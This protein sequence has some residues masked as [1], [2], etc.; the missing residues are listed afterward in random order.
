MSGPTTDEIAKTLSDA[1]WSMRKE[2][3]TGGTPVDEALIRAR[4]ANVNPVEI[5]RA[6]V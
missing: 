2:L 5:G 3:N 1:A 6:H 4:A